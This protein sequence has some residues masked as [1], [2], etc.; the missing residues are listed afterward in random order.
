MSELQRFLDWINWFSF[1]LEEKL[2]QLLTFRCTFVAGVHNGCCTLR[3]STPTTLFLREVVLP[4]LRSQLNSFSNEQGIFRMTAAKTAI[5]PDV[6]YFDWPFVE[7]SAWGF[8]RRVVSHAYAKKRN[9]E[10]FTYI[11]PG[12]KLLEREEM[13]Y[14]H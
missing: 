3:L 9:G 5:E 4:E 6:Y 7:D 2:P 10:A 12:E 14:G 8:L 13:K 1:Y 11:R